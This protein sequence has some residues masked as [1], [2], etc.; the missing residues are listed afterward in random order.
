MN[1]NVEKVAQKFLS[2]VLGNSF[3]GQYIEINFV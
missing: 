3:S 2:M 1:E